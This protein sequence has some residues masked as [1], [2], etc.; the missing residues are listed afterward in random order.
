M[1]TTFLCY[2]LK[3]A[4]LFL[5]VNYASYV[6]I[7]VVV[8]LYC[9]S[10]GRR[11]CQHEDRTAVGCPME[12]LGKVIRLT[13]PPVEKAPTSRWRHYVGPHRR[14][15]KKAHSSRR[16]RPTRARSPA[17]TDGSPASPWCLFTSLMTSL[18]SAMTA[19]ICTP[20]FVIGLP[21]SATLKLMA[22][23]KSVYYYNYYYYESIERRRLPIR[24]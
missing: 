15:S 6:G 8:R 9:I 7:T 12:P 17:G 2:A 20:A 14:R 22:L 5:R 21:T 18:I 4:R 13:G 23:Y 16:A 19:L 3:I 1:V 11:D 24:I 10:D